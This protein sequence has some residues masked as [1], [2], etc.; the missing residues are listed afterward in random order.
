[1]NLEKKRILVVDDERDIRELI[2]DILSDYDYAVTTVHDAAAARSAVRLN[3]FDA[4]LLD[5]WLPGTDGITLLK[6]WSDRGDFD[7]PVIMMS[8][9]GTVQTAV[10]AVRLGAYDYLEKPVSAGRLEITVKNAMRTGTV[11]SSPV[12]AGVVNK[13]ELQLVGSSKIMRSLRQQI[14]VVASVSSNVLIVGEP[15]SGKRTLARMIHDAQSA[16]GAPFIMLDWLL[17]DDDSRP[18]SD[19]LSEASGGTLLIPDLH[20]YD[21]H[22]QNIILGMINTRSE[23]S[24]QADSPVMPRLIA[25][26]ADS[27]YS[28][29]EN[30][31]F[32]REI[33]NRLGEMSV[34][35][36]ALRQYSEDMPE[37]VGYLTDLLSQ[38]EN[39]R[40]KQFSTAALNRLRNHTWTGNLSELITVLRQAL[41][42]GDN[43]T[44]VDTDIEPLLTERA[45]PQIHT[46]HRS[47]DE[48]YFALPFRE[49]RAQF[50]RTY[51]LRNLRRFKSYTELA[52][53]TG[54]H[55]TSLFR[56]LREH[57]IEVTPG[58]AV[59]ESKDVEQS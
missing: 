42:E 9:H 6:E 11:K 58:Y 12:E 25:T 51:L 49:A 27:V 13:R 1:M 14:E 4:I 2:A 53:M 32:R 28:A 56:K 16:D 31:Q 33:L 36:P 39:L 5:I 35:V 24:A 34:E 37:L 15:G 50:E 38:T 10:E 29:V 21:G 45:V 7:T 40:Y 48:Y 59:S 47:E 20:V 54:L 23:M 30:G 43:E 57:G 46:V 52:Q 17:T 26:V 3:H 22:R 18:I 19:L 41:V 44:I 8:A 55:R